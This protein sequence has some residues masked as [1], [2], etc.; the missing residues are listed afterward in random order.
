MQ[1]INKGLPDT[2]TLNLIT[3]PFLV[4]IEKIICFYKTLVKIRSS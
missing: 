4:Q 2:K 1:K 3:S